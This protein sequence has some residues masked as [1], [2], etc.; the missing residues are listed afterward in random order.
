MRRSPAPARSAAAWSPSSVWPWCTSAGHVGIGAGDIV[1]LLFESDDHI[2]NI[3]RGA[4][5]PRLV[6]GG[7]GR[8]ALGAFAPR[9]SPSPA[10]TWRHRSCSA[11][12]RGLLSV[13]VVAVVGISLPIG[14]RAAWPSGRDARR[15]IVMAPP[16]AEPPVDSAR[17]GRL[18]RRHGAVGRV[19]PAPH[20]LRGETAASRVGKRLPS[21]RRHGCQPPDGAG[22][23]HRVLGLIAL[24]GRRIL[25]L[26]DDT[27]QRP[28]LGVR[29]TRVMRR[30]SPCCSRAAAVT[31][32]VRSASLAVRPVVVRLLASRS[33]NLLVTGCSCPSP[34]WPA[35]SSS[36]G[37]TWRS[38][39][40][41]A[42][43][44][45]RDRQAW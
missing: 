41:W 8:L 21:R 19:P 28:R 34:H 9:C 24:G 27:D 16:P 7:R 36:I 30:R 43:P 1:G 6:A 12:L 3:P 26:G 45:R 44:R 33:P 40:R 42:R 17:P 37:A 31:V 10:N 23:P 38:A 15:G 11:S 22:P 2:W 25:A 29:S 14:P 5:L 39:P 13:T 32:A 18:G 20:P 4:R 35:P